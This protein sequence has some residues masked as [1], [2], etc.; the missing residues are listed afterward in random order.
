M[1][2]KLENKTKISTLTA[3]LENVRKKT[4]EQK[5]SEQKSIIS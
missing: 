5:F 2:K 4:N 1:E 3:Q